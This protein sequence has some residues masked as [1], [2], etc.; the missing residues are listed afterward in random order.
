MYTHSLESQP[1]PGLYQKQ[2]VQLVKG[3]VFALL[4]CSGDPTRSPASS[5]G[6]LSTVRTV[7]VGLEEATQMD[8]G[9]EHLFCEDRLR[10]LGLFYLENPPGRPYCGLSVLMGGF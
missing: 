1:Y 2:N 9:L 8:R 6:A 3:K 7:G 10:E 5:S 4:L